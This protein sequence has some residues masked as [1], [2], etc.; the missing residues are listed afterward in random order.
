MKI[1]I[2]IFVCLCFFQNLNGQTL[3]QSAL[4]GK[5]NIVVKKPTK[6]YLDNYNF[7]TR[8]FLSWLDVTNAEFNKKDTTEIKVLVDKAK[9]TEPIFEDWTESELLNKI[10]IGESDFIS[11]KSGLEKIHWETKEDKKKIKKEIRKYNNKRTEWRSFPL[12][13]SRPVYSNNG[14]YALISFIRGNNGGNV[15]LYKKYDVKNW[16]YIVDIYSWAY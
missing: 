12:S 5:S 11:I 16:K 7:K 1:A 13:M 3:F 9:T 8:E 4:N 2:R 15:S 6:I 14:E 10:L